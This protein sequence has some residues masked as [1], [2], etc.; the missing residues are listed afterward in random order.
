MADIK[1]NHRSPSI[2]MTPMVDLAFLLLTFFILTT[3]FYKPYVMNILMPEDDPKAQPPQVNYKRVVTLILG[4]NDKIYWYKGSENAVEV[5][6]YSSGGI[7]Q[8]LLQLNG[9]IKGMVVFIKPSDESRYQNLVDIL[10]EMTIIGI[11]RYY[12]ADI[13]FN[14]INLVKTKLNTL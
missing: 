14:D 11:S 12:L 4:A 5:T 3:T 7:R 8:V 6:D 1:T 9:S 13:T 10:D 2:N